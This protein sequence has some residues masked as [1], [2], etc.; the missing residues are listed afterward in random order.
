MTGTLST[1]S[2]WMLLLA[3][4]GTIVACAAY[5]IHRLRRTARHGDVPEHVRERIAEAR[6]R[7]GSRPGYGR[8]VYPDGTVEYDPDAL[9]DRARIEDLEAARSRP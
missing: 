1:Q 5:A 4:E 7:E 8:T 6:R 9:G 2:S 3:I